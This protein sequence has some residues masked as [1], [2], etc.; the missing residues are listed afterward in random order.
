MANVFFD[1]GMSIDG[2]IAGPNAGPKTPL[3]EGG[4]DLHAWMLEQKAFRE[5]LGLGE[6]GAT[7]PDD[8]RVAE[9][10][11]R[12]GASV[13]GKRMFDEGEANWPEQAP[14]HTPVFVLT[15]EERT[16][17]ARPGGTTFH[18]VNDGI[19]S[20]L[21]QAKKAAGE[22]DVRI[23]GGADVIRQYVQAS[24]VDEMCLHF[25]PV[26][27]VRG[28]RLFEGIDRSKMKAR[29]VG[30]TPSRGVTHVTYALGS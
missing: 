16:P 29:L 4:A 7:G 30:T 24:L 15:H 12:T 14:F 8:D 6:G 3:G 25:V 22:R 18:F 13:I 17:W 27:L 10:F 1:V 9:L 5:S 28:I 26:T 23:G 21:A 19:E 2:F 11:A 20:A